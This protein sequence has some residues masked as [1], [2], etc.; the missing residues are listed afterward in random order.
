MVNTMADF[1]PDLGTRHHANFCAVENGV[2]V[3]LAPEVLGWRT[4]SGE[5]PTDEWLASNGF[6]GLVETP[7]PSVDDRAETASLEDVEAWTVSDQEQT[8]TQNWRVEQLSAT[9]REELQVKQAEKVRTRRMQLLF[10]S[11]YTQVLDFVGDRE[12]WVAY[13]QALRD[14]PAQPGFPWDVVW[15]AE[16]GS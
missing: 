12:V 4:D 13:R 3:R 11:D 7:S 8:V 15:P 2:A 9:E 1:S 16:P 14:V 10:L 6:Y 5:R